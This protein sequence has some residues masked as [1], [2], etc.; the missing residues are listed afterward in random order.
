MPPKIDPNSPENTA[1]ISLFTSLGLASNSATELIRQP[2]S[3]V[4]FKSLID[5]FQLE[6]KTFDEKQAGALV[7]L[8]AAGGKLG[9][10]KRGYVVE[11]IVQGDLKT[12]DQVVG[13]WTCSGASTSGLWE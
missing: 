11:K 7:K 5:E 4:A 9:A 13:R 10:E 12:P 8:S 3:G 1:L 2:K 6:G